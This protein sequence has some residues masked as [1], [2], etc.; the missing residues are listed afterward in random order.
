MSAAETVLAIL[1]GITTLS[2][3]FG[4]GTWW[5]FKQ[6]QKSG[7]RQAQYAAAQAQEAARMESM[8]RQLAETREELV[9]TRKQLAAIQQSQS[10][11]GH[12]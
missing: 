7:K 3:T 4:S 5:I 12:P 8:E 10:G 6:G 11:N 1:G 9:E 2:A